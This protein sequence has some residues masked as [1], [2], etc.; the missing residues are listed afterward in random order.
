MT[1]TRTP[2]EKAYSALEDPVCALS[3]M[4]SIMSF[5][6]ADSLDCLNKTEGENR[7]ITMQIHEHERLMFAIYKVEKMADELHELYSVEWKKA[8]SEAADRV[9]AEAEE[10]RS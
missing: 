6:A 2:A 7:V 5:L 10:S 3:N 9:L 4:A 8:R 1:E